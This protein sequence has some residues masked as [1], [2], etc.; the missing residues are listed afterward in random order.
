MIGAVMV[1][2]GSGWCLYFAQADLW[3]HAAMQAILALVGCW[4]IVKARQG[5]FRNATLIV[6]IGLFCI[7]LVMLVFVDIPTPKAPRA[8]HHFFLAMGVGSFMLLKREPLWLRHGMPLLCFVAFYVFARM[9]LSIDTPL[10][11]PDAV[12]VPAGW[13]HNA[14]ALSIMYVLLCLMLSDVDEHK[15]MSASLRKGLYENQFSLHYQPQLGEDGSICGAEAL[16]RWR[17]PTKGMVSPVE[18]I[19][20]AENTGFI[21]PLGH[22]VLGTACAQLVAWAKEPATE[23]L[24][25]A[26]NVSAQQFRQVDYVAQVLSVLERTGANPNR[27]K[28]ELTESMLVNDVDDIIAKMT[29]LRANGVRLSLDDFGAGYSSLSY[30]KRLPLD[31]IKIDKSFVND[32]MTKRKDA[33]IAR[34][35]VK[36]AQE[37]E[38]DVIAEG[39]ET[40]G[41][42][43][44]LAGIGCLAI[45]GYLVSRA[46]P[47]REFDAFIASF[48]RTTHVAA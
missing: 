2:A 36:L 47:I 6:S 45:Q 39:V 17:H 27:L 24:S 44:F 18:F 14:I 28:L 42:R 7:L 19:P 16:L 10:A 40:Q 15:A 22:W 37:M 9:P 5:Q 13:V 33:A 23:H 25:V 43:D 1:A 32:V 4:V 48:S 11:L 46:L 21:L 3:P 30:L 20:V 34:A 29:E 12:R 26:V 35:I 41:Q 8:L 31:Q 38:L